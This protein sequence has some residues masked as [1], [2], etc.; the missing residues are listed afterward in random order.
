MLPDEELVR[1]LEGRCNGQLLLLT[2][3][4][5]CRRLVPA[6]RERAL[7]DD[8]VHLGVQLPVGEALIFQ[9]KSELTTNRICHHVAG[10]IKGKDKTAPAPTLKG[11]LQ[12]LD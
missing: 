11:Q 5:G 10:Y 9:V 12:P 6:V 4:Q 7:S 2:T 1:L 3:R 8:F